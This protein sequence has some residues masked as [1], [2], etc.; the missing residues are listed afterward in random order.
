MG[1]T[2][3]KS[4]A[5]IGLGCSAISEVGGAFAQNHKVVED[6]S[7]L[8][9][10]GVLPHV[11]G[12]QPKGRD[13]EIARSIRNLLCN[14]KTRLPNFDLGYTLPVLKRLMPSVKEGLVEINGLEVK[15]TEIG[16][17]LSRHV[18]L[19]FDERY[20][21]KQPLTKTFSQGV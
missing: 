13:T 9:L 12:H 20:W 4:S 11:R 7:N 3:H 19:A 1:Y 2:T 14:G 10:A 6:Y 21:K 16:K 15:L 5:L 18:A 8:V 17:T